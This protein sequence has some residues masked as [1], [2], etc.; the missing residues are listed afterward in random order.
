MLRTSPF[1]ATPV[2]SSDDHRQVQSLFPTLSRGSGSVSEILLANLGIDL[3]DK[4]PTG[5][6]DR[7]SMFVLEITE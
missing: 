2:S 6:V 4:S 7:Y 5:V 3:D 1:D